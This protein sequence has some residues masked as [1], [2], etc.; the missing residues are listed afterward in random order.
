MY[1]IKK[2]SQSQLP[3][4]CPSPRLGSSSM[5][6]VQEQKLR[7]TLWQSQNVWRRN[8]MK[9]TTAD[10][11]RGNS[12]VEETGTPGDAIPALKRSGRADKR[13]DPFGTGGGTNRQVSQSQTEESV[14]KFN[15]IRV[16]LFLQLST[17]IEWMMRRWSNRLL[18]TDQFLRNS[19]QQSTNG[20]EL[21]WQ[22]KN[23]ATFDRVDCFA[24]DV[25]RVGPK[26]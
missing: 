25:N 17:T 9:L 3:R 19:L 15:C 20:D 21:K 8:I 7:I 11:S 14:L 18:R 13:M 26:L 5:R 4:N 16:P 10:I 6:T 2:T 22:C 12:A 24:V 1:K 23:E